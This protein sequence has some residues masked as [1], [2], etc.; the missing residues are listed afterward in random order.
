MSVLFLEV[1]TEKS[2][3]SAFVLQWCW[4]KQSGASLNVN[5]T[6]NFQGQLMFTGTIIYTKLGIKAKANCQTLNAI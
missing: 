6:F 5:I 1:P 2:S 3:C 4:V